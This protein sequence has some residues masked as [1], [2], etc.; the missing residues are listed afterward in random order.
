MKILLLAGVHYPEML[1]TIA[2][3]NIQADIVISPSTSEQIQAKLHASAGS[4]VC[5]LE[6]SEWESL[7]KNTYDAVISI[8][9]RRILKEQFFEAFNRLAIV[10]IHPALLPYYK[11]YHTEPYVIANNEK[12]HGITAH[13]LVE[14][15]DAGEILAQQFFPIGEYDTVDS[16]KEGIKFIFPQFWSSVLDGLQSGNFEGS[17]DISEK[18]SGTFVIAPRRT[19][20]DSEVDPKQSLEELYHELRSSQSDNYL[21]FYTRKDGVKI[22]VKL[23]SDRD[24]KSEN[25]I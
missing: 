14:E 11:G 24:D 21:P 5:F 18:V 8:G 4:T 1:E 13:R 22:Y 6:S 10:N 19:P 7:A 9:W 23:I 16:I 25:Q 2:A 15:L 20:A 17:A 3:K 12:I